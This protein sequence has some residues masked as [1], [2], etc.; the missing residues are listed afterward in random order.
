MIINSCRAALLDE[1]ALLALLESGHV[2]GAA[3]DVL[4][5]E[6]APL[7]GHPNVVCTPHLGAST[8]EAQ[9]NVA[10]QIAEQM[11][12]YLMRDAISNAVNFPLDHRGGSAE[13][14]ALHRPRRPPRLLRRAAD[15]QQYQESVD[16]LR[17]RSRRAQDQGADGFYDRRA[18][19]PT[20]RRR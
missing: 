17:G 13:A 7:L 18:A 19:A 12:D 8:K 16:H 3:L 14:E 5:K 10:L 2:A 15:R 4:E 20:A 6:P 9:E 1:N 11:S